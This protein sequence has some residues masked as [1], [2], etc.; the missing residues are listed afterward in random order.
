MPEGPSLTYDDLLDFHAL[1][2]AD[3]WFD[4]LIDLLRLERDRS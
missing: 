2:Q 4:H 3:D 1:L